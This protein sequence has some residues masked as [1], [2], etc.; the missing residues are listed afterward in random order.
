M[1]P[2]ISYIIYFNNGRQSPIH[3]GR[4]PRRVGLYDEKRRLF[5]GIASATN[6]KTRKDLKQSGEEHTHP[7][8][9]LAGHIVRVRTGKDSEVQ[10]RKC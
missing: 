4:P 1:P 10:G 8:R 7:C 9:P 3:L 5:S 6:E 2:N